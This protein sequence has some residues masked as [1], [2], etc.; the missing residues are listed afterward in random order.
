MSSIDPT[1]NSH[2]AASDVSTQF[3]DSAEEIF[4]AVMD[5]PA[6]QRTAKV[7][8]LVVGNP[9]LETFVI[10]LLGSAVETS[11]EFILDR[12]IFSSRSVNQQT[13]SETFQ[14]RC[15]D[16]I[17]RYKLVS[18]IGEGG[19]GVVFKAQQVTDIERQVAVKILKKFSNS[20]VAAKRFENEC[21]SM[22]RL[23][24]SLIAK[25]LDAGTCPSGH[26][27][28]VVEFVSGIDIVQFC[29]DKKLDL[30]QR[31]ELMLQVLDAVQHAHRN[32]V[33]HRDL[34][35]SNILVSQHD[36]R[37]TPKI[38]DFGVS[39]SFQS[40]ENKG[41]TTGILGTMVGTPSYMSPE[42]ARLISNEVDSRTDIYAL[43][44]VLYE[45]LTG[46]TPLKN[47]G[48]EQPIDVLEL[49]SRIGELN[50][51]PPS[52]WYGNSSGDAPV[53]LKRGERHLHFPLDCIVLECLEAKVDNRYQSV[54]SLAS[55]IKRL[56]N[57]DPVEA[58]PSTIGYRLSAFAR[59]HRRV[60]SAIVAG[61]LGILVASTCCLVFA[62]NAIQSNRSKD[63]ALSE[64]KEKNIELETAQKEII[65]KTRQRRF[66]TVIR[67]ALMATQ[68]ELS[69]KSGV[70]PALLSAN[71]LLPLAA[72]GLQHEEFVRDD[73]EVLKTEFEAVQEEK[74]S[75]ER[76]SFEV[77]EEMSGGMISSL[78]GF[79]TTQETMEKFG[80]EHRIRPDSRI[81]K[82]AR[83]G[84]CSNLVEECEKE[85][86]EDIYLA[87]CLNL[88]AAT[89]LE[90]DQLKAAQKTLG[91]AERLVDSSNR[92]AVV[93]M[94]E[95]VEQ[96]IAEQ[97]VP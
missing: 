5:V 94:M 2:D 35:P 50:I 84:F 61:A 83:I 69:M 45:L 92:S 24:H 97:K 66:R 86:G 18:K 57:N 3:L 17:G 32:G 65:A 21:Q 73:L 76:K 23:N 85:F 10:E 63:K 9:E 49:S 27:F 43:G 34:K 96:R 64:L 14:Y 6:V 31:L 68:V 91:R 90:F 59:K 70:H 93:A 54:D 13:A 51:N 95:F 77:V 33:M 15:G 29:N 46:T 82:V 37:Y 81:G 75:I 62:I 71:A 42:Q 1:S 11:K 28:L 44:V 41:A 80:E 30:R 16:L 74:V 58:V 89:Q 7:K 40:S 72:N 79:P 53:C 48:V 38:I 55:D 4:Y 39:Q 56:L 78:F 26:F 88:L 25:V 8:E 47:A 19:M 87:S 36:D 60:A 20:P 12:P 67:T 22:A 52:Q